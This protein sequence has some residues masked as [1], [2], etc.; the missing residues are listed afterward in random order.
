MKFT[1][2]KILRKFFVESSIDI[3]ARHDIICIAE[4]AG[5]MKKDY[6]SPEYKRSRG[7]YAAQCT[8]EYFVSLLVTDAFL[9]KLLSS[10]GISDALVGIISSFITLAFVIQLASIFLVRTRV[11]AKKLVI[12]FDTISIFFFMLLYLIPFMPISKVAKTAL[13]ICCILIAYAGNY[14]ILTICYKWANSFVEPIKRARYSANKEVIS[15]AGGM[16]FTAVM[17]YII[18]KY[19]SVGNLSGGFLFI[20]A[21]VLVLNICD[22]I[23]LAMIKKEEESISDAGASFKAVIKHTLGNKNFRSVILLTIMWDMARYFSIGF[24]GTFKTK[25]LMISLFAVQIINIIGNL[26]RMV[27]SRPFGIYSD[28]S[29]FAK[30]F[31]VALIVAA[32][33]FFINI[34]T[35]NSTW[36]LVVVFTVLYNICL[37]G[38]NQNS[39]NITYNY[40]DLEYITQAMAIKN[41]IGGLC[42]FGASIIGGKLLGAVQ[43]HNNTIFG[44]QIYGQQILSGISFI[45]I[46]AAIVFVKF[47]IEK[48]EIKIQ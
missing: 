40:V 16:I 2:M 42:G 36:Y 5:Y 46:A 39:Y 28:K 41:S 31:R 45:I 20:A 43:A 24:M 10:I 26:A 34:F 29:S 7:A 23:C 33:A 22:F 14:L 17:G 13:V 30:G 21:S 6:N 8:F 32:A 37:A 35:T 3:F 12:I 19:E 48:Q 1:K 27:L 15:L 11:S 38:T 47:G 4:E 18:D 25:D 9:A 44:M